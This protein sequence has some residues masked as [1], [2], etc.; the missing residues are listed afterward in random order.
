MALLVQKLRR[1]WGRGGFYL[2]VE[3]HWEGSVPA[4]SA[5]G[6]FKVCLTNC[7]YFLFCSKAI[8]MECY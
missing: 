6:L 8:K 3:L 7:A 2:V 5:A 4:A 1:F